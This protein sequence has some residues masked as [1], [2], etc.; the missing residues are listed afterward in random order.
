MNIWSEFASKFNKINVYTLVK[1]SLT[2][3]ENE[4]IRL[5]Q[6]QLY[7]SGQLSDG[8]FLDSYSPYTIVKKQEARS[9]HDSRVANMTLRDTGAF[10]KSFKVKITNENVLVYATDGKTDKLIT[11]FGKNIFGLTE[12]NWEELIEQN[13][14]P[15]IIRNINDILN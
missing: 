12:Q 10:Y 1:K 7:S 6:E 11:D 15:S 5:N 2:G 9:G 3:L 4:I 13:V 8:S 14:V